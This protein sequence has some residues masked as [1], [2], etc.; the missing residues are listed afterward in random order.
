MASILIWGR[1][2]DVLAG[3][4]PPGISAREVGSLAE[5]QSHLDGRAG[6]LVLAEPEKLEAES[7]RPRSLAQGRRQLQ[8]MFVAVSESDAADDILKRFP[9]LD[10]LISKPVTPGRMRLRLDRALEPS[11]AGG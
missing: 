5:L 1:T 8:A 11:T 10:D 6:T 3:D 7:R 4:L 2:R 9:F